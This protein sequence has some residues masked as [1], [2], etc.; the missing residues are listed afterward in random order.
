MLLFVVQ[1]KVYT[2]VPDNVIPSESGEKLSGTEGVT[3]NAA[4]LK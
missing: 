4:K 1:L 3:A 2:L